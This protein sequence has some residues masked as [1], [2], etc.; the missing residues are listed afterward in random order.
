MAVELDGLRISY[1]T[2]Q[3]IIRRLT[4]A[5]K[6]LSKY[7]RGLKELSRERLRDYGGPSLQS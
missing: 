6:H 4:K 2:Y 5:A 1:L 3:S 7:N